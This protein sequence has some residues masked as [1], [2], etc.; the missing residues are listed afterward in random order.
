VAKLAWNNVPLELIMFY[1]DGEFVAED[2]MVD[3]MRELMSL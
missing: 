2:V 3:K 1:H